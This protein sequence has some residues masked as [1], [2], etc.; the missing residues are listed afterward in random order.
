MTDLA[1][2]LVQGKG[3]D[4]VEG[5][6]PAFSSSL[7]AMFAG[8]PPEIQSQLQI[9]SGFRSNERQAQLYADAIKKYGSPEAARHW[10]APPGQSQH[11]HGN[12]ADLKFLNPAAL[13]W[14]HENA[15]KYGL[16]FPMGHENWHIELAGARGQPTPATTRPAEAGAP[17]IQL[18]AAQPAAAT[19]S[20][21]VPQ[22]EAPSEPG[23]GLFAAL[24][25]GLPQMDVGAMMQARESKTAADKARRQALFGPGGVADMFA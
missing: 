12:A 2:F 18:A 7:A 13:T 3:A 15:G 5:F 17:A 8:A 16:A 20:T 25:E 1:R 24:A 22:L 19:A 23:A 14:A 11:N 6:Q 21:P 10:V 9:G 4:S